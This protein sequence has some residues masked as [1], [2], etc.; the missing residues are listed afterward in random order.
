MGQVGEWL[1]GRADAAARRN[2]ER[3]RAVVWEANPCPHGT[4][5]NGSCAKQHYSMC[6]RRYR[7]DDLS[8]YVPAG[9]AG[10]CVVLT[11]VCL[12]QMLGAVRA[13]KSVPAAAGE[14]ALPPPPPPS[15]A[16]AMTTAGGGDGNEG[17]VGHRDCDAD[18]DGDSD[19]DG[20]CDG[21]GGD[22]DIEQH[23]LDGVLVSRK[24][25]HQ[26]YESISS[27]GVGSRSGGGGGGSGD[28]A[29]LE[30]VVLD[31]RAH[32]TAASPAK[33]AAAAGADG[34]AAA[35]AAA[36]AAA[37]PAGSASSASSPAARLVERMQVRCARQGCFCWCR[38]CRLC[39]CCCC[40]RRRCCC[41]RH[42]CCCCCR[43]CK[44][45]QHLH[46]HISAS[47]SYNHELM[48]S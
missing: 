21:G 37:P 6:C 10:G 7:N 24:R 8:R 18:A 46:R 2:D 32:V 43:R 48:N 27:G 33:K 31:G 41:R 25:A 5:D 1:P 3:V 16:A 39:R 9:V 45:K 42:W 23:R 36:A 26:H 22:D 40:R 17:E 12:L 15:S 44:N 11:A 29:V 47:Y 19:D 28:V 30:M 38:W 34:V 14:E 35:A 4:R 13:A 20:E